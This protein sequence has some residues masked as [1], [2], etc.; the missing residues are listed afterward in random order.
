M[1]GLSIA[2]VK[3]V[4]VLRKELLLSQDILE[5]IR[6]VVKTINEQGLRDEQRERIERIQKTK[7]QTQ[8]L[9]TEYIDYLTKASRGLMH[10]E[11]WV[12]IGSR[13]MSVVDKL[14]GISYRL[15]FLIEKNW[16]VPEKV[17]SNF[18][19][20]CDNLSMMVSTLDQAMN[21]LLSSPPQALEDLRKISEYE[22]TIDSLYRSTIF[23][24][25][26]SNI[27]S[28]TMLLLLGIAEML[29]DSSDILYDLVSN[30]YIILLEST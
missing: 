21:K 12:R 24:V 19:A 3:L 5:E 18:A 7:S 17:A 8:T 11:E 13:V 4:S 9:Q 10:R 16:V 27:S 22:S 6:R 15:G 30:L 29:E 25:L 1:E 28:S 14:S 23:E 2:D 20:M 26:G